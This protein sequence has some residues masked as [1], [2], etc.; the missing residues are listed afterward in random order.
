MFANAMQCARLLPKS[1]RFVLRW[2]HGP[3][4]PRLLSA[5]FEPSLAFLT[6]AGISIDYTTKLIVVTHKKG[7]LQSLLHLTLAATSC[8]KYL[9]ER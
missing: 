9:E 6:S 2:I 5:H 8:A 1:S 4:I 3:V 7:I